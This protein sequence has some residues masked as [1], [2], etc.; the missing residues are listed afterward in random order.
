MRDKAFPARVRRRARVPLLGAGLGAL[1]LTALHPP[2]PRLVW[3]ASASVPIGLYRVA[4]GARFSA[5]DLVLVRLP[6]KARQLAAR[7][8]YLPANVPALK[9]VAATRGMQICARGDAILIE[10]VHAASRMAADRHGR[11]LPHWHGC[12]RLG[13]EEILL[14]SPAKDS[15]DGRYFGPSARRD[16]IGTARLIW[17]LGG[18]KT[19]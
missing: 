10:G 11:K 15:F 8:F 5:G 4:P 3:N 1:A 14:L 13:E 2:A 16:V 17:A 12:R 6:E 9:R 18:G 19:P 7:R